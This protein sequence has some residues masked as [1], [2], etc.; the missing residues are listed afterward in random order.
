MAEADVEKLRS[1]RAKL[2]KRRAELAEIIAGTVGTDETA[3]SFTK[4]QAAIVAI[5]RAIGDETPLSF[6]KLG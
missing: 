3:E 1:A 2:V 6:A 4:I 5:D